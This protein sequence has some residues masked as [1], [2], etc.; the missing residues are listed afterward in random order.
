MA[1]IHRLLCTHCTFGTSELESSSGDNVGKVLGYSVRKSSLPDAERGQL[2]QVFRAVERLLSYGLPKDATAAHKETLSAD[3]APRRLIFFP[4]LGG[5]QV[6]GQVSYRTFDTS[7]P[8]RPG[9]YFADLIV[10]KAP[11]PRGHDPEPAWSPCDVLQLWGVGPDRKTQ[12]QAGWWISSEDELAA[13]ESEGPWK[14]IAPPSVAAVREPRPPLIDDEAAYRF[15]AADAVAAD[16]LVPARWWAMP[17]ERRRELVAHMLQATIQGPA[18]GGRETVTIAAEPSVAAVLFYIVCR[19]LPRRIAAGVSFSTYEPAPERPLTGLVATTFL[20]EEAP[21]A[22]LPPELAQR[23][24]ACNT[25][26]DVSAFG[27]CQ[28]PPE[29]GYARRL[30]ALAAANDWVGIDSLLAALDAEGLKAAELDRLIEIDHLVTAYFRGEKTKGLGARRGLQEARFLRERFRGVLETQAATRA[31]WPSDLLEAA[32]FCLEGDLENLWTAGGPVRA[33]LE[34]HLPDG[35]GLTRLLKPPQGMPSAPQSL[36][37]A[38]VVS[39]TLRRKKQD[40]P[41]S[42]VKYCAA[43]SAGRDREAAKAL[44]EEVIRRLPEEKRAEVLISDEKKS[45]SLADLMLKVAGG[46]SHHERHGLRPALTESLSHAV[47]ELRAAGN[48]AAAADLLARHAEADAC[49][50]ISA[51][52]LGL[53]EQLDKLF[54]DLVDQNLGDH[55][56]RHLVDASGRSLVARLQKWTDHAQ[57]RRRIGETLSHWK[58]LHDAVTR[59]AA[60]APAWRSW[61]KP[62][63]PEGREIP[64]AVA[65]IEGLRPFDVANRI[66]ACDRQQGLARTV[67]ETFK[68]AQPEGSELRAGWETVGHWLD[69]ALEEEATR[70][71]PQAKRP[72]TRFSGV[73]WMTGAVAATI[74]LA[75]VGIAITWRAN[76]TEVAQRDETK[77]AAS[78]AS[79]AP[80]ADD[81]PSS[82]AAAPAAANGEDKPPVEVREPPQL[83][84]TDIGLKLTWQDGFLKAK[85]NDS[86]EQLLDARFALEVKGP[87]D[88]SFQPVTNAAAGFDTKERGFGTYTV[89]LRATLRDGKVKD[90]GEQTL[91]LSD[92]SKP[93]LSEHNLDVVDGRPSLRLTLSN[94]PNWPPDTKTYGRIEY[95]V[96][97][98]GE[99]G[100]SHSQPAPLPEPGSPFTVLEVPLDA[101]RFK[102]SAFLTAPPEFSIALKTPQGV[103][104]PVD[105]VVP[106]KP[107]LPDLKA[108]IVKAAKD[109]GFECDLN[110]DFDATNLLSL[111]WWLPP[112][113]FDLRL[114]T[115]QFT[116]ETSLALATKDTSQ[117]NLRWQCKATG[118]SALTVGYFELD[119]TQPWQPQLRFK[120]AQQ[121]EPGYDDAYTKLRCCR[122]CLLINEQA[123]AT[124]QLQKSSSLGPLKIRFPFPSK[125]ISAAIPHL[126][127]VTNFIDKLRFEQSRPEPINFE[128][129]VLSIEAGQTPSFEL[130]TQTN[131]GKPSTA[132][133]ELTGD[134][135]TVEVLKHPTKPRK[136]EESLN[137]DREKANEAVS[138]LTG[139]LNG[140]LDGPNAENQRQQLR[141]K[142]ATAKEN[143]AKTEQDLEKARSWNAFVEAVKATTFTIDDWR[144]AWET[145]LAQDKNS[146]PTEVPG[147]TAVVFIQGSPHGQPIVFKVP[148]EPA[149]NGKRDAAPPK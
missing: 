86:H 9:S 104:G 88:E 13:A 40:L 62:A 92:P 90:C 73:M 80:S 113:I 142:I 111:P 15:L 1:A 103:V 33:L 93:V 30:V 119:V 50:W 128:G 7:Q 31:D 2:R 4:N 82:E 20:D 11:D 55:S 60:D 84:D 14:P 89:K 32:I 23:G 100:W 18:R 66:K 96:S 116:S 70:R 67:V 75:A 102:P 105:F 27:R 115:P 26:R 72:A 149:P 108:S 140:I 58:S 5:W 52:H 134:N 98:K 146:L 25:F 22:D 42:F 28:P 69:R 12:D 124:C 85:W 81:G 137:K 126:D 37:A 117:S 68:Q 77:T 45:A 123:V 48:A 44:L 106:S 133:M 21:T 79:K 43:A 127:K 112:K 110:Q 16:P 120:P 41:S 97:Q 46:L 64:A 130:T 51:S 59:L 6:A 141:N 148:E 34:R 109:R 125:P 38:A 114:M 91:G 144:I 36:V 56:G 24:F 3:T 35:D 76:Q 17:A 74:L 19:L 135:V 61:A 87:N 65:A 95:V 57:D 121:K 122:V 54:H 118:S 71:T 145:E 139:K 47:K 129:L 94:R 8:A 83:S 39:A 49:A 29:Q 136:D 63:A 101:D 138:Q 10:A 147:G 107:D 99:A 143:L 78:A 53:Q 132:V 131:A